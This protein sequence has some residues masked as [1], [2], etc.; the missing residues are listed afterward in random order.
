MNISVSPARLSG[1]TAAIASKSDAHRRLILAA[2]ADAPTVFSLAGGSDDINATVHCLE[3]LGAKIEKNK[4]EWTV[5]PACRVREAHLFAGESGSTL[6]FLLPVAMAKCEKAHFAGAGRLP[7]RPLTHLIHAMKAGGTT[8]S[9]EKLPLTATGRMKSGVFTV[10][11]NISSQYVTGLLMA[12]PFLDGDS[13]IVVEGELASKAYVDITLSTM[14]D[15][16]LTVHATQKGYLVPGGQTPVSKGHMTIDGDWSNAAF[17]LTAGAISQNP[18][19]VTGLC[20][21][22]PQG[23]KA[24]CELLAGFGAK[25]EKKNGAVTVTG[26]KL[27]GCE[28]D[29]DKTPDLIAPLGVAAAYARG[30]TVFY[31][32]ARLRIKESDRIKTMKNLICALG[33]QAEETE[34]TLTVIGTGALAGGTADGANDHRIVMAAAIAGSFSENGATITGAEAVNKSYPG[35]FEDFTIAGGIA[36]V[37]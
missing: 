2:F 15:F 28:I 10:P 14:R 7:E 9:G 34:D 23:D 29:I 31:N 6:R 33:G 19:T 4:N 8:F 1:T 36:N 32:G 16:G 25:V 18:V 3:K 17:F 26:G 22:S 11:G 21:D 20:P 35:F 12:L 24:I 37:I 5:Y 27:E 13:E 30:K